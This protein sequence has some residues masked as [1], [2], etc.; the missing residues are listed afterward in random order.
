MVNVHE[1][2]IIPSKSMG[3]SSLLKT[4]LMNILCVTPTLVVKKGI[5]PHRKAFIDEL[6]L[7]RALQQGADGIRTCKVGIP[8]LRPAQGGNSPAF[9]LF[10]EDFGNVK[11]W[12]FMACKA[13][14]LLAVFLV[15][16]ISLL[17]KKVLCFQKTPLFIF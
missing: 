8:W 13:L 12:I 3:W 4:F 6:L 17:Q 9:S 11:E 1:G 5:C 15:L 16:Y 14:T 10:E 2:E 7:L